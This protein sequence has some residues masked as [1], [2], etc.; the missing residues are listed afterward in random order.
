MLDAIQIAVA[1][2]TMFAASVV[3]STLG[4]GIGMVATPVMLLVLEPQTVVVVLN[5]VAFPVFALLVYQHR[6]HLPLR[7]TAPIAVA[8][9]LGAP[10]GVL[11]LSSADA[12]VLR[13]SITGLILVL[14]VAIAF[15]VRG[16]AAPP[17]LLTPLVG[18][19]VGALVIALGVGGPFLVLLL[20]SRGWPSNRLRAALALF[21]LPM[22]IVG[23]TGYGVAGLFTAER[24]VLALIVAV[25][26]LMGFRVA[27]WLVSRMN[28]LM[29]RRATIAVI[30]VTSTMVLTRELFSI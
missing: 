2:A 16:P 5:I 28:E 25:P 3:V 29:F 13:I 15:N 1:A 19:I 7:E 30:V 26:A 22:V 24:M 8:G 11:V 27:T 23:V 17:R 14:T 18:F 12:S 4:F 6:A 20:L 9:L 10:V 21:N